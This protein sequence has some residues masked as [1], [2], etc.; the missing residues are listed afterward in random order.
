MQGAVESTISGNIIN[1]FSVDFFS[2][3]GLEIKEHGFILRDIRF[4]SILEQES[5]FL[6]NIGNF[7]QGEFF[8]GGGK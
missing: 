8:F 3:L 7:L 5:F 1:C 4:F 6:W 2:C